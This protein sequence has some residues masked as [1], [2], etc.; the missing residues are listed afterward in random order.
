VSAQTLPVAPPTFR[1]LDRPECDAILARNAV[2]RIAYTLR[3][4]VD[5]EPI[6]YAFDDGW[7]YGRTS[8]GS[9][10]D[11]LAHH[12][13]VAFEVDEI[14]GTFDW[15]SVV[16]HGTFYRMQPEGSY[17][18]RQA[19]ARALA[20][21]RQLLPG[22]LSADDPVPTRRVVFGVHIDDVTGRAASP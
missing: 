15:A 22:T 18:E 20:A 11:V 12:P 3:G 8:E 2:G 17:I 10:L 19:Y 16:V 1:A 14:R 4:R 6:H 7:L 9:K 13:W 5:I 21:L